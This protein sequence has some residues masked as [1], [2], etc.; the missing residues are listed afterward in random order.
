MPGRL[1]GLYQT[2]SQ[3]CTRQTHRAVPD[4]LTGLYQADSRV[5]P[6]D[7]RAV[8]DRL[9]GLYQ[10]DSQGCTMLHN[11]FYFRLVSHFLVFICGSL[12]TY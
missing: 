6:G 11:G 3:G 7:S 5:V 8:P 9:T 4:R 1:I 10:A 12:L 2:D